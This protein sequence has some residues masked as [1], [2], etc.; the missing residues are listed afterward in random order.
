MGGFPVPQVIHVP[1]PLT[2]TA[3]RRLL[4]LLS[5]LSTLSPNS[6]FCSQVSSLT[7][8]SCGLCQALISPCHFRYS[9]LPHKDFFIWGGEA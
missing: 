6:L 1:P 2:P 3:P 5:Q 9:V 7:D 8:C 4:L